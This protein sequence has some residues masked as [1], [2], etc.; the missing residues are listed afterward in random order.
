MVLC[1]VVHPSEAC[2]LLFLVMGVSY[3]TLACVSMWSG[4]P[5]GYGLG[6]GNLVLGWF[7]H[8]GDATCHFCQSKAKKYNGG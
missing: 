7:F 8:S 1:P 2:L 6:M 5:M 3:A 4:N